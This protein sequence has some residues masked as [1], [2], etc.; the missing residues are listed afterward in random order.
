[1]VDGSWLVEWF[2]SDM[3]E[4]YLCSVMVYMQRLLDGIDLFVVVTV[5]VGW[6]KIPPSPKG[7][8]TSRSWI[9]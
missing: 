6:Q 5:Q 2:C 4:R 7:F 8:L 3:V 1:M 9:I